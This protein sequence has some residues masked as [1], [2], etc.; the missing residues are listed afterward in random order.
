MGSGGGIGIA[1]LVLIMLLLLYL[2]TNAGFRAKSVEITPS[3]ST[4]L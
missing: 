4:Y 1:G 3:R 2:S